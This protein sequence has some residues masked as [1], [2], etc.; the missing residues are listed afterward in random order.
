M[1]HNSFIATPENIIRNSNNNGCKK[2]IINAV[3]NEGNYL[4]PL[5]HCAVLL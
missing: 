1:W 3:N 2:E 5:S 4:V